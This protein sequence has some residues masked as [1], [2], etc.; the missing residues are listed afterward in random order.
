M[1]VSIDI[2]RE[3]MEMHLEITPGKKAYS[4]DILVM[5]LE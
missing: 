1:L 4:N 2:L 3:S 5:A